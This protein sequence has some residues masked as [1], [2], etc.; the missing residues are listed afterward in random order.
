MTLEKKSLIKLNYATT[1]QLQSVTYEVA[2]F[3]I[4]ISKMYVNNIKG[5]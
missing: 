4:H 3:H 5:S 2:P 1:V